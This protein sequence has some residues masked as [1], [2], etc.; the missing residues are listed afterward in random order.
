MKLTINDK[1]HEHTGD[2]TL[3]SLLAEIN[4]ASERVA[5]MVNDEVISKSDRDTI[6]LQECDKV[7][8]LTFAG[9]G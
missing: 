7:E 5:I 4:A 3:K 1:E 8:V 9:G 6:R 2:G